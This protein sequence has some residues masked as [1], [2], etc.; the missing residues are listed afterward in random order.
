MNLKIRPNLN[1]MRRLI[2]SWNNHEIMR[3]KLNIW[4]TGN[5]DWTEL[6]LIGFTELKF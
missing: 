5:V 6:N 4:F 3:A 2:K 1:E